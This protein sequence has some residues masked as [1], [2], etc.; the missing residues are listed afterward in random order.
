MSAKAHSLGWD[1]APDE[2]HVSAQFKALLFAAAGRSGDSTIIQAAQDM[3]KRFASGDRKAIHPNLRD[4]VYAIN[5]ING[6]DHEFDVIYNEYKTTTDADERITAL[7]SLGRVKS[8]ELI[9]RVIA[10]PLGG[11][12]RAQ[13]IYLPIMGLRSDPAGVEAAW[14][15]LTSNWEELVRVCPP[16]LSMLNTLVKLCTT[17]FTTEKQMQMVQDWFKDKDKTGFKM[18]LEQSL[19]SIR[20]KL[21]WVNRD[22]KDVESFLQGERL[23]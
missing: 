21:G 18:A 12:V 14:Q 23:L 13:D 9:K 10:L 5:L 22:R 3:F 4:H 6:G 20:V 1:F 8:P 2:G 19:D 17:E 15:W 11:D 7:R 16:E